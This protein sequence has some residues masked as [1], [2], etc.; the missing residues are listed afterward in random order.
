MRKNYAVQLEAW[1][2]AFGTSQLSHAIARLE[3]AEREV[4]RLTQLISTP[5]TDEYFEAV[6]LEAAHQ[7]QIWGRPH[8]LGKNPE[9]W[10]FLFGYLSGKASAAMRLSDT[11]K[12]LHRIITAG[13]AVLNWY[14][15]VVGDI[16]DMRPGIAP[17]TEIG[18]GG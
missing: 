1:Q 2:R 6:K 17:P 8:D 11:E 3:T 12:G 14:R 7:Q 16:K 13:A 15:N 5:H 4:K 18:H 9:D 10:L